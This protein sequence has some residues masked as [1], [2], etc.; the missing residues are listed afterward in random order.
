M[1][2]ALKDVNS[3]LRKL[4][5]L[6]TAMRGA[7]KDISQLRK[8]GKVRLSKARCR[9]EETLG[10][11]KYVLREQNTDILLCFIPASSLKHVVPT[12]IKYEIVVSEHP[13]EHLIIEITILVPVR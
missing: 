6:C 4:S 12:V 2:K 8:G 9:P 10:D 11:F 3:F 13:W 1:W 5:L 7:F